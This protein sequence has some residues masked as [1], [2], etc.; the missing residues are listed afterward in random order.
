MGGGADRC[1][2]PPYLSEGLVGLREVSAGASLKAIQLKQAAPFLGEGSASQAATPPRQKG[3]SQPQGGDGCP[4]EGGRRAGGHL[5][6]SG[7][8][9]PPPSSGS[10]PG[11]QLPSVLPVTSAAPPTPE[12]AA[13]GPPRALVTQLPQRP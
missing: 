6:V 7:P 9:G 3:P 11:S 10:A 12:S 4:R 8:E 2:K 5:L 1:M 13:A